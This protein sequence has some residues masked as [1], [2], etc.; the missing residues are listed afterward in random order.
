MEWASVCL[1]APVPALHVAL[2]ARA[3]VSKLEHEALGELRVI[4]GIRIGNEVEGRIQQLLV[5]DGD[6]H[7]A[8]HEALR[9]EHRARDSKHVDDM[10]LLVEGLLQEEHEHQDQWVVGGAC[11]NGV[12]QD[13]VWFVL[14]V[15]LV[16]NHKAGLLAHLDDRVQVL[17]AD[18]D[19]VSIHVHPTVVPEELETQ[20]VSLALP[21][22]LFI[23]DLPVEHRQL[24]SLVVAPHLEAPTGVRIAVVDTEGVDPQTRRLTWSDPNLMNDLRN[25]RLPT[26]VL[27]VEFTTCTPLVRILN[28]ALASVPMIIRVD[29]INLELRVVFQHT[30]EVR[31]LRIQ[32][33]NDSLKAVCATQQG[34]ARALVK[35]QRL[36][37]SAWSVRA[38]QQPLLLL[39]GGLHTLQFRLYDRGALLQLVEPSLRPLD[40]GPICSRTDREWRRL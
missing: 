17:V 5:S 18:G 35:L 16:G 11:N 2:Q 13:G 14:G 7:V 19:H 33:P 6:R 25:V 24:S 38:C 3:S 40:G 10:P 36:H 31:I 37:G 21:H 34:P 9:V 22:L 29:G 4:N 27:H 28:R 1:L 26:Q 15:G 39:D 12:A 20:D 23:V 8:V 32:L 30:F